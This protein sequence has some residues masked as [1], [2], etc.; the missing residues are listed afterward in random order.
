MKTKPLLIVIIILLL[1]GAF[2]TNPGRDKHA[3]AATEILLGLNRGGGENYGI[4]GG[5][6]GSFMEGFV[7]GNLKID[8]YYLF[9]VS[10]IYSESRQKSLNLGLGLFDQVIPIASPEDVAAFQDAPKKDVQEQKR[11]K[12]TADALKEFLNDSPETLEKIEIEK[13]PDEETNKALESIM[14]SPE[15]P[16]NG[17][18]D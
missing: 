4:L 9:S 2:M 10:S 8:N 5:L 12:S 16:T 1:V 14:D 7:G 3:E 11:K 15:E 6:L 13:H 17:Y 18:Y